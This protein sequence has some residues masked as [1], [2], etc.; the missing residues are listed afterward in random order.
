MCPRTAI[1]AR[2]RRVYVAEALGSPRERGPGGWWAARTPFG[3]P[4]PLEAN[5]ETPPSATEVAVASLASADAPAEAAASTLE[6]SDPGCGPGEIKACSAS[7]AARSPFQG[8]PSR[9]RAPRS[10]PRR[11]RARF[12]RAERCPTRPAALPGTPAARPTP[13]RPAALRHGRR[14]RA[15][16]S[17][18]CRGWCA[19]SPLC[20]RPRV[21]ADRAPTWRRAPVSVRTE[22]CLSAARAPRSCARTACARTNPVAR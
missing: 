21:G 17:P 2:Q 11:M 16:A 7:S 14:G 12:R 8:L 13:R 22:R 1:H 15:R 19:R 6:A 18:A 4:I 3:M 9:G 10:A 5:L 20:R